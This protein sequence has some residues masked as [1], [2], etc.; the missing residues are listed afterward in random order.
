MS[1]QL[2]STNLP[3]YRPP[4]C[5]FL[6]S[7]PAPR[8]AHVNLNLPSTGS[9][10]LS[11][12]CVFPLHSDFLLWPFSHKWHDMLLFGDKL[13]LCLWI[14]SSCIHLWMDPWLAPPSQW[15]IRM[16][17]S[18]H[19]FYST[20]FPWL[21]SRSQSWSNA[22]FNFQPCILIM[23][24][25]RNHP[26]KPWGT[27]GQSSAQLCGHGDT[28]DPWCFLILLFYTLQGTAI[29]QE[30]WTETHSP[31]WGD[32]SRSQPRLIDPDVSLQISHC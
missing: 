27:R 19:S 15:Q 1:C 22:C 20:L 25:S 10:Y 2:Y 5:C 23:K 28:E 6:L 12:S 32:P 16:L 29:S 17:W 9:V 31:R 11:E 21:G 26:R 4:L 8:D 18:S 14:T 7:C 3:W 24:S 13:P 30:H